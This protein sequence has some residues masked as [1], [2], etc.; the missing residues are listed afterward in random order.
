MYSMYKS[1]MLVFSYRTRGIMQMFYL[2]DGNNKRITII[3]VIIR[4]PTRKSKPSIYRE[5]QMRTGLHV[6]VG[7][8]TRLV[9]RI[10]YIY[11]LCR[12]SHRRQSLVRRELCS[13]HD[14][15]SVVYHTSGN[16]TVSWT[17]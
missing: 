10:Y 17:P 8:C 12:F 9:H 7:T 2:N 3:S 15:H 16:L 5:I 6:V 1:Y 4:L 14:V 13:A 11:T